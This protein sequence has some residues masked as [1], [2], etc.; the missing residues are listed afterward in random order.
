M[1]KLSGRTIL[2]GMGKPEDVRKENREAYSSQLRNF[3][4]CLPIP[5]KEIKDACVIQDLK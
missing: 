4:K 2:R 3:A 1:K 5:F